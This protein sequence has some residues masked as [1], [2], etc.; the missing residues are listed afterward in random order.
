MKKIVLAVALLAG[1]S[2][3]LTIC[4][5][6]CGCGDHSSG[7][8]GYWCKSWNFADFANACGGAEIVHGDSVYQLVG[9]GCNSQYTNPVCDYKYVGGI[10]TDTTTF[11]CRDEIE[12]DKTTGQAITYHSVYKI[13][14]KTTQGGGVEWTNYEESENAPMSCADVGYCKYGQTKCMGDMGGYYGTNWS[15]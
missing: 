15:R 12:L 1:L 8:C 9:L 5:S 10:K 3:A 7:G 2:F 11:V 6:S 14:G 4:P 13:T